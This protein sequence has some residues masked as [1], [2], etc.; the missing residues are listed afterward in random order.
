MDK[1]MEEFRISLTTLIN[2]LSLEGRCNT[3]DFI[4]AEYLVECFKAFENTSNKRMSWL[5]YGREI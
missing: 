4:L 3:P 2:S 1:K 5:G